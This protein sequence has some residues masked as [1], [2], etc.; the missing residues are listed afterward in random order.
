MTRHEVRIS[1]S[2]WSLTVE[3]TID[4]DATPTRESGTR[5]SGAPQAEPIAEPLLT[6]DWE[7]RAQA[8]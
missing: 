6:D 5:S 4:T 1:A 8:A 2:A 7:S 3:R